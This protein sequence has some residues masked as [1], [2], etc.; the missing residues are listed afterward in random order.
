MEQQ[1]AQSATNEGFLIG[2]YLRQQREHLDLSLD[3]ISTHTNIRVGQLRAIEEGK[4]NDLPGMTYAVGFVRAYADFMGL[5]SEEV[6]KLFKQEHTE[7]PE[8]PDLH[9]PIPQD[10]IKLPDMRILG[11]AGICA[12]IV[13]IGFFIF[14][15]KSEVSEKE[16]VAV[17]VI[18]E[19]PED[20]KTAAQEAEAKNKALVAK[21][22][23]IK[24]AIEKDKTA[25]KAEAREVITQV[26]PVETVKK[27]AVIVAQ[28]VVQEEV[29]AVPVAMQDE[30]MI[31]LPDDAEQVMDIDLTADPM[32]NSADALNRA[33][34]KKPRIKPKNPPKPSENIAQRDQKKGATSGSVYGQN[35]EAIST[36]VLQAVKVSWIQ[37]RDKQNKTIFKKLLRPGDT[38]HVPAVEGVNLITTN[39]GGLDVIVAG[40]KAP[41]LGGH[42]EII[43]GLSLAPEEL[44]RKRIQVRRDNR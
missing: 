24:A 44:T 8:K 36:V 15:E 12:L 23:E 29:S 27:E 42:G 34:I 6:A 21:A 28:A 43:R 31:A 4:L 32:A 19:V 1:T 33:V 16:H 10:E 30:N 9:L 40:Q 35:E 25:E 37:I 17:D 2:E 13:I 38:Y 26:K 5:D 7:L 39:A 11:G 18:Q 14:D 20:I 22:Q 41:S 3:Y